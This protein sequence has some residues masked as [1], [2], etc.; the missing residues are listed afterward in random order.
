[1]RI[2]IS[3]Y[4]FSPFRGSECAVGWNIVT[5]MAKYHDVTV[6]CG[7]VSSE[8]QTKKDLAQYFSE[9]LAIENLTIN[10][11]EP[12]RLIQ[13]IERIHQIPGL[14]CFY[15]WAYN[16]WQRKAFIIARN[17]HAKMPFD[18]VHQLNMIGYREPGYLWKLP[19]PF[20]WGPVGGGP[21]ESLAFISQF[22]WAGGIKVLLRTL[23][24]EIQKRI[25]IRS[26]KAAKRA[27]KVWAVTSDDME[28]IRDIW[29]VPV[30]QMSETGA[31]VKSECVPL[32]WCGSSPLR[33]VWSGIHTSR[34]AMPIL[35]HAIARIS[36][37]TRLNV[38]VLGIGNETKAWKVLAEQLGI[39]E[40]L[41]W[42]GQLAH[43]DALALM[44]SSHL[45]AFTSIK[46]GTPHVVLEA[47]SL[48][49]PV[50][51]HDSCGMGMAVN[52][53]CGIKTPLKTPEA[54]IIGFRDAI[55]KFLANPGMV[56]EL[57]RGALSRAE[58]LSWDKKVESIARVYNES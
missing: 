31:T 24:N 18:L 6:L 22:S 48:G 27:H 44:K 12:S 11:V 19:I 32:V 57:S 56:E 46:E 15:Y 38:D 40:C 13:W 41:T 35:L 30:E 55:N 34:K 51:C 52:A 4:A 25:S 7:D 5:R 1:M 2:L 43:Q 14:W 50:I 49:L 36:E 9:S 26:R 33:I 28:M 8:L 20:I 23:L 21:N 10:Y 3:A 16:L 47:L 58:E 39:S 37:R 42:H 53:D 17:L 54:S 45:L 29:G